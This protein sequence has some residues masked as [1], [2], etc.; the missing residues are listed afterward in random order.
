MGPAGTGRPVPADIAASRR[1]GPHGVA[2]ARDAAGSH[3]IS[4][5]QTMTGAWSRRGFLAGLGVFGLAAAGCVRVPTEGPIEQVNPTPRNED[6]TV[7]INP[8]PPAPDAS[9]ALII[10][11]FLHAMATFEPGYVT[12]RAYLTEGGGERWKPEIGVRI[13]RDGYPASISQGRAVLDAPLVA[14]VSS[15]GVYRRSSER[16]SHDFG[17]VQDPAG[18]WRIDSPPD[19]LLVPQYLFDRSY[20]AIPLYFF[21]R[22]LR[23]LVASPIHLPSRLAEPFTI[24]DRLLKGPSG[25]LAEALVSLLP[26]DAS[27]STLTVAEGIAQINLPTAAQELPDDVRTRLAAQLV[28]SLRS[29]G[30]LRAIR[31][32]AGTEPLTVPEQ[33]AQGLIG[34]QSM[35]RFAPVQARLA[36]QTFAVIDGRVVR[37]EQADSDPVPVAGALGRG[38]IPIGTLGV[39]YD[40]FTMAVVDPDRRSLARVTVS[41]EAAAEPMLVDL[42]RVLR[43]Q[44]S[45]FDEI[46]TFA[47]DPAGQQRLWSVFPGASEATEVPAPALTERDVIGFCLSPDGVRLAVLVRG[48]DGMVRVGVAPVIREGELRLGEWQVLE[49][50]NADVDPDRLVDLAWASDTELLLVGQDRDDLRSTVHLLGVDSQEFR[51]ISQ[52]E[53]WG[54]PRL[55]AA[56]RTAGIRAVVV[57]QDGRLWRYEDDYRWTLSAS[58]VELAVF[59]G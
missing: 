59:P 10:D 46:W 5:G 30:E 31:L 40:G 51:Q 52:S 18:Q 56:P 48:S 23:N 42:Q 25:G 32:F 47:T 15:A 20:V 28:W 4:G 44:F 2:D 39:S 17:L 27:Q 14:T 58:S 24:F 43:P 22:G 57:S 8:E 12:A 34:L 26:A 38:E 1:G 13:P 19:G 7:Q 45:R 3:R 35:E 37:Q 36:T 55:S 9:P 50:A 16:V 33:G 21:E 41:G 6:A 54:A 53:D 49:L 29:W 11:G